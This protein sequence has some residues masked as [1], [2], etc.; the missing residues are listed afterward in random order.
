MFY[1]SRNLE[2]V[3]FNEA[4]PEKE[5]K[6][7]NVEQFIEKLKMPI[8]EFLQ[9]LMPTVT[10]EN[11]YLESWELISQH[12]ASLE[13]YSNVPLLFEYVQLQSEL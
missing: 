1:F 13:Q 3:L 9:E 2:H 12:T 11:P 4:N 10:G 8:E 6:Y 5:E 7:P